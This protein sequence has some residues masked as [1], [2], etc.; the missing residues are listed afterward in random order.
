MIL[1]FAPAPLD[2]VKAGV[3]LGP[4]HRDQS[5]MTPATVG[6]SLQRAVGWSRRELQAYGC[7]GRS[8]LLHAL[9]EKSY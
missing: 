9:Q 1:T 5:Q 4:R 3:P 2:L 6:R 7:P 8:G